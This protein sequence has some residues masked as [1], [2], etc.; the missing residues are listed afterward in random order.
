MK[1]SNRAF[2]QRRKFL[3]V[4][5]PLVLPFVTMIFWALGGGQAAPAQSTASNT[6]LNLN[7]P[8]AHF[9]KEKGANKLSIYEQAKTD[10]MKHREAR[11]NDPYIDLAML[12]PDSARDHGSLL[13]DGPNLKLAKPR[14]SQSSIDENE[15]RVNE[16]L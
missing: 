15:K 7:L 1:Q 12:S 2:L 5:P 16:R 10:S 6:G 8:D 4:L 9:L 14:P 13:S 11:E 3:M